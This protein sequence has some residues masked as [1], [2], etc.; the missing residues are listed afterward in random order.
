[1]QA[2]VIGLVCVNTV[3]LI[4]LLER[5]LANKLG[6]FGD[7]IAISKSETITDSLID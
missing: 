6:K 5:V 3:G 7:A 1:M 2:Y 4:V